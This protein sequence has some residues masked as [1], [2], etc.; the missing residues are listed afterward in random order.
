MF[1]RRL[2]IFLILMFVVTIVI[3]L[4][5]AHIQIVEHDH[6]TERAERLRT[7]TIYVETTR[8]RILDRKG[9]ELAVDLPCTDVVIDYRVLTPEPDARWVR[10][11]AY[12]RLR[13]GDWNGYLAADRPTR[14]RILAEEI[15]SV[16]ADIAAMWDI[17]AEVS[18]QTRQQIDET[19]NAIVQR[20]E[21]RKRYIWYRGYERAIEKHEQADAAPAWQRWLLGDAVDGPKLDEFR[22]EVAEETQSH[23]VI[24]DIGVQAINYLGKHID[25]FPG[26]SLRP[27]V[28]RVYP[29]GDVACHVLGR[30]AKVTREDLENDLNREDELRRYWQN[31]LIGRTGIEAL[32]EPTLRG[33]RG[34]MIRHYGH[35]Q[36]IPDATAIPGKDVRITLDILLQK[37]VQQTFERARVPAANNTF[38]VHAMHGAAVVIDVPTGE[39]RALVSYP[40][41][42]LNTF[43]RDYSQ[44]VRDDINKRLLNRATQYPLEPGS[45]VKPIVGMGAIADGLIAAHGT[46]ECTGYLVIDGRTHRVGRC[47]V[48]SKYATILG[49]NGVAHHPIPW[50]EPHPDGFLS[51]SDALQRS[52][53]IFF[54][55][56]A[57]K[58]GLDGLS[59]WYRQFG[60]GMPVGIGIPEAAGRLPDSFRGPADVRRSTSW[61]AGIGQGQVAATPLQMA[62][63]AATI[64]R[65][66]VWIRP[67]LVERDAVI[68]ERLIR[69][70]EGEFAADRRR[71]NVPP[72]ALEQARDGMVRVAN[73]RAGTGTRVRRDDMI[74]AAKTGTAQA[75]KM[76]VP[77]RDENGNYVRDEHDRVVRRLLEPSMPGNLNPEAIWYRAFGEGG[78]ELNHAWIIG[79]AP[80][81]NPQVAFAV[82]VEYGGS[83]G[84]VTSA[85]IA[86]KVLEACIEHGYLSK[87]AS[88]E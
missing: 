59:R 21:S 30:V 78:K 11:K 37:E 27:G 6:W 41:Y 4:K 46:I 39:I 66:G 42:D 35:S 68:D 8:G 88:G 25:R 71:L 29:F 33:S 28:H 70:G 47:W 85:D 51:L 77:V 86:N 54:E 61:F 81:A 22:I 57:D 60:L 34:R 40:T 63:V 79:Y 82:M 10:S 56:L 1:E 72:A 44:L 14:Q 65:N 53:N 12:S 49:A 76:T 5:A 15:E 7:R 45:T 20:V 48:A 74:V 19:R 67:T 24:S 62:N 38:D 50:A 55:T 9:E 31:D 84:G 36:A 52:C 26:M 64:A 3:A 43:D 69:R 17:L 58:M 75:A 2:K 80:A 16:K 32:A 13:Q 18:G 23:V 87:P 73:T 83:G